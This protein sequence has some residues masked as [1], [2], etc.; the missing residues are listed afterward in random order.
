V[1]TADA[2]PPDEPVVLGE[3]A[4]IVAERTGRRVTLPDDTRFV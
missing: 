4:H 1:L 3:A 2:S